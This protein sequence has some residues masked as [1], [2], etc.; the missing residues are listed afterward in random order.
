MFDARGSPVVCAISAL[1]C[2]V[3]LV[4]TEY[5]VDCEN[6][7]DVEIVGDWYNSTIITGY[8]GASYMH[9]QAIAKWG[10]NWKTVLWPLPYEALCWLY[11]KYISMTQVGASYLSADNVTYS[12]RYSAG[13]ETIVIDQRK[14]SGT[15]VELRTDP[16]PLDS[17]SYVK[18]SCE[19]TS[20]LVVADAVK[21]TCMHP[22]TGARHESLAM[23]SL[24]LS[25]PTYFNT[26]SLGLCI[27]TLQSERSKLRSPSPSIHF[28]LSITHNLTHDLTHNHTYDPTH[29]LT[30]DLTHNL[31]YERTH[32]RTHDPTHERTHKRTHERTHK[33]THD[34]THKSTYD[35]THDLTLDPTHDPTHERA[36]N[37]THERAHDLTHKRTYDLTH[38]RTYDLTHKRTYDLTHKLTHDL[39]HKQNCTSPYEAAGLVEGN[40]TF[41]VTETHSSGQLE[42]ACHFWAV[43]PRLR[44]KGEGLSAA[45]NAPNSRSEILELQSTLT[46]ITLTSS[47]FLIDRVQVSENS[48]ITTTGRRR[49]RRQMLSDDEHGSSGELRAYASKGSGC[50]VELQLDASQVNSTSERSYTVLVVVLDSRT[51]Y[52]SEVAAEVAVI[53]RMETSLLL[54]PSSGVVEVHGS[55]SSHVVAG[56]TAVASDPYLVNVGAAS[57]DSGCSATTTVNITSQDNQTWV[58]VEPSSSILENIGD[59]LVLSVVFLQQHTATV[60]YQTATF[61][62]LNS[63]DS[64]VQDLRVVL[65]VV[66]DK[67]SNQS[68]AS[69]VDKD[70]ALI[71]GE[72]AEWVVMPYDRFS[73]AITTGEDSFLIDMFYTEAD[74][75]P[76]KELGSQAA[77]PFNESEGRYVSQV[78]EVSPFG[79]YQVHLR[80]VDRGQI[81]EDLETLPNASWTD[82]QGCSLLGSPLDFYFAKVA[83]DLQ[84]HQEPDVDG[85]QC[86]CTAGYYNALSQDSKGGLSCEAC[87]HGRYGPVGT[88][89]DREAACYLCELEG[90]SDRLTTLEPN[91]TSLEECVCKQGHH[92]EGGGWDGEGFRNCTLC[93]PGSYQDA[94]N[95][96][97]CIPCALGTH[98]AGEG[99]TLPCDETC[100]G[101]EVS[102]VEGLAGCLRCAPD[103]HAEYVCRLN[104]TVDRYDVGLCHAA[105]NGT[106]DVMCLCDY[107]F[108]TFESDEE[109]VFINQTCSAC[110]EG[111]E[112]RYSLFRTTAGHWRRDST[113]D[114]TYEC[115]PEDVCLGEITADTYDWESLAKAYSSAQWT[116]TTELSICREGHTSVMCGACKQGWVMGPDEYCY[117][118]S[119]SDG[120][121]GII[122]GLLIMLMLGAWMQRPFKKDRERELGEKIIRIVKH[123]GKARKQAVI[124]ARCALTA[125]GGEPH[126]GKNCKGLLGASGQEVDGRDGLL[127]TSEQ[128]VNGGDGLLGNSVQ[129]VD[130]REDSKAPQV[131]MVELTATVSS[132]AAVRVDSG[133]SEPEFKPPPPAS[134]RPS[135]TRFRTMREV[136]IAVKAMRAMQRTSAVDDEASTDAVDDE[137]STNA[138]DD[139]ASTKARVQKIS[140]ITHSADG[141]AVK[142]TDCTDTRGHV[143]RTA[144]VVSGGNSNKSLAIVQ[145]LTAVIVSFSQLMASFDTSLGIEWPEGFGKVMKVIRITNIATPSVGLS[146]G[147]C[148]FA[149]ANFFTIQAL[150]VALPLAVIV[151]VWAAAWVSFR[152]YERRGRDRRAADG[153]DRMAVEATRISYHIYSVHTILFLVYI[154]YIAL[155]TKMLTYFNCISV[156]DE[157]WLEADLNVQCWVGSH[158]AFLPLGLLGLALYPLGLPVLFTLVLVK[159]HVPELAR[160]K[161]RACLLLLA[162]MRL[163]HTVHAQQVRPESVDPLLALEA[164]TLAELTTLTAAVGMTHEGAAP[165]GDG[166]PEALVA[167]S[168]PP[169]RGKPNGEGVEIRSAEASRG[170][171]EAREALIDM[172]TAWVVQCHGAIQQSLRVHWENCED[173]TELPA[174][175]SPAGAPARRSWR[176]MEARAVMRAGFIF[177]AYH[178]QAWWYESV[179]LI[180]K[181]IL[182]CLVVFLGKGSSQQLTISTLFCFAGVCLH[183]SLKPDVIPLVHIFTVSTL[184]L[185]F[186]TLIIGNMLARNDEGGSDAFLDHLLLWPTILLY[187]SFVLC[188]V[189]ITGV[190]TWIFPQAKGAK[191]LQF[192]RGILGSIKIGL[193]DGIRKVSSNTPASTYQEVA[194]LGKRSWL[195]REDS[196]S[197]AMSRDE[198][199]EDIAT[200]EAGLFVNP[201]YRQI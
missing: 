193:R 164:I 69:R 62:I 179:D 51:G 2:A 135:C 184:A 11:V 142:A 55:E 36:H 45:V 10:G 70:A 109:G 127:A 175:A 150:W 24:Q 52:T 31:T 126:S 61:S 25:N 82:P 191:P 173:L 168:D 177:K 102:P 33:R 1:D 49:R 118:C 182:G 12:V 161:R 160:V 187:V 53:V 178:A 112:C 3:Q 195:G 130:G 64:S 124:R 125:L 40:H 96:S 58:R 172:L 201:L 156:H 71:T 7:D 169:A 133:G 140:K 162:R 148:L 108:Y 28:A 23:L 94:M 88:R 39:T 87:G 60:A 138:V 129:A 131:G 165:R 190:I 136:G 119:A 79:A 73:N 163:D 76:R 146:S 137:A 196:P 80:Y 149:H 139:K 20:G 104:G 17:E 65:T 171:E 166:S 98:S 42:V 54:I 111:A 26:L 32:K 19:G 103:T 66:P 147:E 84:Q 83:C 30:H 106:I 197:L 6:A 145:Q 29:K 122:L 43:A 186:Y 92:H 99:R 4:G 199:E 56:E 86:Q 34:L 50:T 48:T 67:I 46:D 27:A 170:S 180:R 159:Y 35:L 18:L 121:G 101:H 198:Y 100:V 200:Y 174:P 192:V 63:A 107:G 185:L 5:I 128:A 158:R 116:E 14:Y 90:S 38:K 183:L 57:L 117:E 97:A 78:D 91:A 167:V 9:N 120:A 13:I 143:V 155:S 110:P 154:F 81:Q 95:T 151:F 15:W 47:D 8:H 85:W 113:L 74:P 105:G 115:E 89:M 144:S 132:G 72:A 123:A 16:F 75:A 22:T 181:L 44:F 134:P 59:V 157:Y 141:V 189:Y 68:V 37:L 114:H 21:A 77:A 194:R 152:R 93:G 41:T 188:L 153:D 176:A